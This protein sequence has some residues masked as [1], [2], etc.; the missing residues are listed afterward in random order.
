VSLFGGPQDA[1]TVEVRVQLI[2]VEAKALDLVLPTYIPA[3]DLTQRIA[4]DAGLNPHWEDGTR[5]LYWLRARGRVLLDEERLQDLGVSDGELLHLLPQPPRDSD[6]VERP[7]EYPVSRGYAGA[8]WLAVGTAL[9]TLAL[10]TAGWAVALTAIP[11]MTLQT[12]APLRLVAVGLLPSIG[13]ALM[14]TSFSR[15][16]WGGDGKDWKVPATGAGVYLPLVVIAAVPAVLLG[17]DPG[18]LSIALGPG[19]LAGVAGIVVGWLAW[20]GAVEP[21]PRTRAAIQAEA[22]DEAVM[23]V[24]CGICGGPVTPDVMAECRHRCGRVFHAGCYRAR[25]AVSG[26]DACAVCGFVPS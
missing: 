14:A 16:L 26:G 8:G 3:R 6:V 17:V 25:E 10:W 4:T 23:T 19:L 22:G 21:L 13:L 1:G 15:H 2:D 9:A 11:E 5:R 18:A 12:L 7:P 24:P 20:Y